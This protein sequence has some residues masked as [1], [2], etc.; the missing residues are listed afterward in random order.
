MSKVS[1]D[2]WLLF[3]S[4]QQARRPAV[5][6]QLL[7]KR[8]SN[9]TLFWGMRY[10]WLAYINLC[11]SID[12]Q[13]FDQQIKLLCQQKMLLKQDD[14]TVLLTADGQACQA[15]LQAEH[16]LAAP[17]VFANYR[18][19]DLVKLLRLL[20][21]VASEA[22]WKNARYYVAVDDFECQAVLK[23]WVR[24]H[25]LRALKEQLV[26]ELKKFLALEDPQDAWIFCSQFAG[27]ETVPA[28]TKQVAQALN[29]SQRA[30][31]LTLLDLNS[32]FVLELIQTNSPLA[33]MI[34]HFQSKNALYQ[35]SQKTLTLI[36]RGFSI[37][38]IVQRSQLK[39]STILEHL[40]NAAIFN[41]DFPFT[42]FLSNT[43][44]Q[45]LGKIL[46]ADIDQ[47]Q[48]SMVGEYQAKISFFKYR[49]YAIWRTREQSER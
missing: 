19:Y 3:F 36:T 49:L 32:R 46:P 40:L 7:S 25:G 11:P 48:Y 37:P 24:A 22:S 8:L 44:R 10:R 30:V 35:K 31:E 13:A 5:L 23:N 14:G 18:V 41:A 9:S 2:N 15:Q 38:Q 26:T 29:I 1:E 47:W 33:P 28:T 43:E 12:T 42:L 45:L 34:T 4:T 27:H 6:R 21:Q 16:S 39:E 20:V 17:Q